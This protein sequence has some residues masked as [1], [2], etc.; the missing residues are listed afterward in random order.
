MGVGEDD[1]DSDCDFGPTCTPIK[2]KCDAIITNAP[3]QYQ[4]LEGRMRFCLTSGYGD[5]IL[6]L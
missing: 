4:S 1:E 2:R 6:C 5:H 3:V